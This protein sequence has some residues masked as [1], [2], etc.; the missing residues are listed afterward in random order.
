MLILGA[1][2]SGLFGLIVALITWKLSGKR[3]KIKFGQEFKLKEYKEMEVF[4]ASLLA[5]LE[6]LV[7]FIKTD[8]EQTELQNEL[9]LLFAKAV[10]YSNKEINDR[11]NSIGEK[12][13]EW[14]SE[15]RKSLP[16][17]IG[18]SS[19]GIVSNFTVEHGERADEL[20]PALIN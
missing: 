6:K 16:M 7:K 8:V 12:L 14:S 20:Y 11:L 2:V 18:D 13:F 1:L 19:H 5:T 17:K 10:L 3:E 15:Y 9:S 4:Y